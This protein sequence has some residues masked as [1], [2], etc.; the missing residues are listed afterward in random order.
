MRRTSISGAAQR[1]AAM[2]FVAAVALASLT[3]AASFS[4]PPASLIASPALSSAPRSLRAPLVPRACRA[5]L[6]PSAFPLA[7]AST[8]KDGEAYEKVKGRLDKLAESAAGYKG[9]DVEDLAEGLEDD[10]KEV[11]SRLAKLMAAFKSKVSKG[12]ATAAFAAAAAGVLTFVVFPKKA[13]AAGIDSLTRTPER[14][15]LVAFA[16]PGAISELDK[17]PPLIGPEPVVRF[18]QSNKFTGEKAGYV[19]KM[20]ESGVGYYIDL[21]PKAVVQKGFT[22]PLQNLNLGGSTAAAIAVGLAGLSTPILVRKLLRSRTPSTEPFYS[23]AKSAAPPSPFAG[24]PASSPKP[25]PSSSSSS[26]SSP[27]SSASSSSSSFAEGSVET[28][29]SRVA[30][31]DAA[32]APAPAPTSGQDPATMKAAELKKA[33]VEMGG[34][35]TGCVEKVELVSL[36]RTLLAQPK[37]VQTQKYEN[38]E[39]YEDAKEVLD[40]EQILKDFDP[41]KADP[42]ALSDMMGNPMIQALQSQMMSDPDTMKEFQTAMSGGKGM[43]DLMK[44]PKF[45]QMTENLMQDPEVLR[46]MSNPSEVS[47]MMSAMKKMGVNP[48]PM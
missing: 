12:F 9:S 35:P 3:I 42:A 1:R 22:N 14:T 47:K 46:M 41:A 44:N 11:Q 25:S 21:P 37:E 33:I 20:G 16:S 31:T 34:N 15:E 39:R 8:D 36:Y 26:S 7:M 6:R 18:Y 23:P 29:A 2:L 5:S 10:V 40:E 43:G 4:L 28:S 32:P 38:F 48:P 24:A 13:N 17:L 30:S 19:F 27:S 45:K